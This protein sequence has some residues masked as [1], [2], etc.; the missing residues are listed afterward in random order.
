VTLL[1]ARELERRA[2][3]ELEEKG[4]KVIR[5]M[6]S[7]RFFNGK[8]ITHYNDFFNVFD[9]IAVKDNE[10]RFIQVTSGE[11]LSSHKSKIKVNFDFS[12][13]DIVT[14]ELWYYYKLKGK[15]QYRI[16]Y[17]KNGEWLDSRS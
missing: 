14:I 8:Y 13:K 17:L 12:F 9:L 4:Y 11:Q 3:K 1:N 16:L 15:W 6:A 5:A 7:G 2:K 10:V